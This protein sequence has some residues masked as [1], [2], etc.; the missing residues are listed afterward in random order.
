MERLT[1]L[2][3]MKGM[4]D[5]TYTLKEL[6]RDGIDAILNNYELNHTASEVVDFEIDLLNQM[7]V[8]NNH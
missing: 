7:A 4:G 3:D 5:F 2:L 8:L 1:R 6:K